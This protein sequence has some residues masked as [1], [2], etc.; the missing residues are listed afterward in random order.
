MLSEKQINRIKKIKSCLH[1]INFGELEKWDQIVK[2]FHNFDVYYLADYVKAFKIHKDGEPLLF[3]YEDKNIKAMNVVMKRDIANDKRF[4]GKIAPNVFYDIMTPYGYG[5]FL[6]EGHITEESLKELDNEY[7]S[8]CLKEGIISEFV[9]F[10]PVLKNS[11]DVKGIYDI[12]ILGKTITMQLS[13]RDLILSNLT[14]EKRKRI[15]K[16]KNS[17]IEIYWGRN[18][19]L[20]G[21]FIRIYNSTMDYTKAK[22]YY[23]FTK[24][25]FNSI[26]HD[27]KYHSSI[28]YAMDDKERIVA[29]AIFLYANGQ[30]NCFLSASDKELDEL[31]LTN[32]IMYEVA[33]W[34]SE[35]GYKTLHMGGGVGGKEDGVYSFKKAFNKNS[36]TNFLIGKKIFNEEKYRELV[37]I[38][39][40][41][42]DFDEETPFFPI[43]RSYT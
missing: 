29:M 26:L 20:I 28:F 15:R 7:S 21:E 9:R 4:I 31:A 10:H 18:T 40:V 32:L 33:C 6:I 13:S 35:N 43:Y 16:A 39:G 23:Y 2:S 8:L 25:F 12:S 22:D 19:E 11:E 42:D 24:D 30:I 36:E 41:E 14:S 38:R 17:G 5:G 3:Y 34:G 37:E 1:L 27:L